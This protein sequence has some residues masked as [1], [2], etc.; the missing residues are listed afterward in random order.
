MTYMEGRGGEAEAFAKRHAEL[1]VI[2]LSNS[3]SCDIPLVPEII[4]QFLICVPPSQ[5]KSLGHSMHDVEIFDL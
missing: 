5:L 4:T 3:K 2:N 1:E